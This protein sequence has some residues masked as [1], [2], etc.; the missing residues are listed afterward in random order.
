MITRTLFTA[1]L[2]ATLASCAAPSWPPQPA[3]AAAPGTQGAPPPSAPPVRGR[4]VEYEGKGDGSRVT[5]RLTA[6]ADGRTRAEDS[7]QGE[8]S[9][10]SGAFSGTGR[11]QG[12]TLRVPEESLPGCFVTLL[13]NGRTL[14]VNAE[15]RA[16]GGLHGAS[17]SLSGTLAQ[18]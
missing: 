12:R 1:R 4:P 16:C 11:F 13:R 10:C 2:L 9:A 6:L 7:K 15:G 8:G 3:Y 18:R 17:C 14:E 5:A